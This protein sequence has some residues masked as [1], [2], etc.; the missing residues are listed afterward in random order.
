MYVIY[1]YMYMRRPK[2]QTH[3]TEI[4]AREHPHAVAH[5][6]TEGAPGASLSHDEGNDRD[7]ETCHCRQVGRDRLAL[8][9]PLRL[10]RI[11]REIKRNTQ[12]YMKEL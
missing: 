6:H 12:Q 7:F 3:H 4:R 1:I 8:S 2:S 11:D 10:F 9:I 5:A